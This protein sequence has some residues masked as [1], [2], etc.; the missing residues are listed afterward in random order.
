MSKAASPGAGVLLIGTWFLGLNRS[1]PLGW[2]RRRCP[3][4]RAGAGAGSELRRTQRAAKSTP[5]SI[6]GWRS[7]DLRVQVQGLRILSSVGEGCVWSAPHHENKFWSFTAVNDINGP[8][9][10]RQIAPQNKNLYLSGR[11]RIDLRK[12][13]PH[14]FQIVWDSRN[15]GSKF[16]PVVC[17]R[18]ADL[19][20]VVAQCSHGLNT[21]TPMG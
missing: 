8:F 16:C 5:E 9:S 3:S 1:L 7:N 12:V 6:P 4:R 11:L 21:A 10:A 13:P 18:H 17:Q 19:S 20:K 2:R 14:S 15:M